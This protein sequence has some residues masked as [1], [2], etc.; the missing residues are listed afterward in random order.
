MVAADNGSIKV[1]RDLLPTTF[2][3]LSPDNAAFTLSPQ[4]STAFFMFE[5]MPFRSLDRS[6]LLVLSW[7]QRKQRIAAGGDHK[8]VRLWD[9]NKEMKVRDILTDTD[10]ITSLSTDHG[11]L[12][13]AGGEDGAVR[14]F[15]DRQKSSQVFSFNDRNGPIVNAKIWPESYSESINI[16]SGNRSG[17]VCWY[18]K[19]LPNK[20]LRVESTGLPMTAMNFHEN[21]DVFA[22][23][24]GHDSSELQLYTLDT[25]KG[26]TTKLRNR[27]VR[28]LAFHGLKAKIALLTNDS[29]LTIYKTSLRVPTISSL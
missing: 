1:W 28:Q 22:C 25:L 12:I 6:N 14:L 8:Y 16:V 9:A 26:P 19:R 15:D 5:D 27:S 10:S 24:F 18:D 2:P 11:H 20:A 3:N 7:D 4:L 21:T 13:C 17:Q 29:A 23:A